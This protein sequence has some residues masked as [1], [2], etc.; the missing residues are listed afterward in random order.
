[1]QGGVFLTKELELAARYEGIWVTNGIRN[2]T[3]PNA[4]NNQTLNIVTVGGT[5]Y[6]NR[7]QLKLTTD[8][9]YAFNA[10]QFSS[11]LFGEGISGA[12]WRPTLNAATAG[13]GGSGEIVFR[14]QMQLLF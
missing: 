5:L 3:T 10:V 11:G 1:V 13:G 2:A 8:V 9:G 12:D 4:L 14:S 6:F 7:N